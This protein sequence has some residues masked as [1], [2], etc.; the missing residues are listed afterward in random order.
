MI[1]IGIL[2][3]LFLVDLSPFGGSARFYG[4]WISCGNKPVVTGGRLITSEGEVP[5]YYTPPIIA[6]THPYNKAFCTAYDAEKHG[7]SADKYTYK[8]PT[9]QEAGDVCRKPTD[10]IPETTVVFS[11]CE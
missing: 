11:V 6:L 8:F 9:L 5:Y 3:L 7:Y 4:K 10:P 2:I 1:I